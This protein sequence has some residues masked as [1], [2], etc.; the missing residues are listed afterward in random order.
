MVDS[1]TPDFELNFQSGSSFPRI[2]CR[3]KWEA[4]ADNDA[5]QTFADSV[6]SLLQDLPECAA[7]AEVEWQLFKLL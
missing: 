4:L 6:S 2:Y 7:C 1:T 5:K 3:M